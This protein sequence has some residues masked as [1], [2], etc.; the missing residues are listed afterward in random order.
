MLPAIAVGIVVIVGIAVVMLPRS[1]KEQESPPAEEVVAAEED[2]TPV[3]APESPSAGVAKADPPKQPPPPEPEPPPPPP[4]DFVV[5][6]K[7]K[8]A[9]ATT[10]GS[11]LAM[12]LHNQDEII[13]PTDARFAELTF[14]SKLQILRTH[15][16][17]LV[18]TFD[19]TEGMENEI[20]EV[21][22]KIRR[23]G[24]ALRIMV[25]GVRFSLCT[26]RDFG[27]EYVVKGTPLTD[28]L[29]IFEKLLQ[30][31]KA[32]GGGDEPEAV[33]EG[34]RWATQKN[35]FRPNARKV[36][37]LFGDAPPHAQHTRLCAQL[38]EQFRRLQGGVVSTITC[39][40]AGPTG[41]LLDS[42]E[43]PEFAEIAKAG[44][45]ESAV[46]SDPK[47]L[48]QQ[49][50]VMPFGNDHRDKV[51]EV[52]RLLEEAEP[53]GALL[54][55]QS[56][57]VEAV[58][59][60]IRRLNE[61]DPTARAAARLILVVLG[62][63]AVPSLMT[64][65]KDRDVRV[66]AAS[67]LGEI[68]APAEIALPELLEA[69]KPDG[70]EDREF[71]AAATV[72]LARL[73]RRDLGPLLRVARSDNDEESCDAIQAL[74]MMGPRARDAVPVFVQALK[75]PGSRRR[76][77]AV[78]GLIKV[79]PRGTLLIRYHEE[80]LPVLVEAL[81]HSD[82]AV[83]SWSVSGLE[84]LGVSGASAAQPLLKM[85]REEH[86]PE[87][88]AQTALALGRVG[89]QDEEVLT[90]LLDVQTDSDASVRYAGARGLVFL[91][92]AALC[93]K[94]KTVRERVV[95]IIK[96][97]IEHEKVGKDI[98]I[99]VGDML[100]VMRDGDDQ[101]RDTAEALLKQTD[102]EVIPALPAYRRALTKARAVVLGNSAAPRI[103]EGEDLRFVLSEELIRALPATRGDRRRELLGELRQRRGERVLGALMVATLAGSEEDQELV[104][105]LVADYL[106]VKPPPDA[107]TRAAGKL[108]RARELAKIGKK[109]SAEL[110]YREVVEEF[111]STPAAD[112]ARALLKK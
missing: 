31:I 76:L 70:K 87:M 39:R 47:T 46:L 67:I 96:T 20:D 38:A 22:R 19:S 57:R 79:D 21:K 32:A 9:P 42:K 62:K 51:L 59:E 103:P 69:L 23:I 25:P 106:A 58:L 53:K 109:D 28:D 94:D 34:L 18:I 49:L 92:P 37:L 40:H 97:L 14:E 101:V 73:G 110:R 100:R 36:I 12:E 5:R 81:A 1:R 64:V 17:D 98:G 68:G 89:M 13:K 107:V 48:T 85:L 11:Q 75:A 3:P 35:H 66:E 41:A 111:P 33:Q 86:D 95:A 8:A 56:I 30:P 44:G 4:P 105:K 54:E 91:G 82:R 90:T 50:F 55:G 52:Y 7:P 27:D 26:Y 2:T 60:M 83:R 61:R 88:R 24:N 6:P 104:R 99:I 71:R 65:L 15:G 112:E 63:Q 93:H 16:L 80:C 10:L 77:L 108:Q 45:G 78:N 102:P 29:Q 84:K 72:A 43:L 74:A